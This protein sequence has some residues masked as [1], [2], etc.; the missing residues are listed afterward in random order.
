MGL[1]SINITFQTK[2]ANAIKRSQK[3]IVAM[4]LQDSKEVGG[5]PLFS[6]SDIPKTLS[7]ENQAQIQLAFLGYVS[8][9]RQVLLYVMDGTKTMLKDALNYFAI[10]QF[11]YLVGT[12]EL[13]EADAQTIA[14]WVK[15]E[16][17]NNHMV[18]AV[19]PN[20]QA[21]SEAI[22]NFTTDKIKA[23]T[24]EFTTAQYCA[25]IAGL[26][27]GTP[28]TIS[29]T[30][31]PLPDVSDVTRKPKQEL[32]SAID[33]GEFILFHDGE[34]VKVGRGVTSLT[35]TTADK[36]EAFQ[37]I[38]IVEA[39][40][41]IKSDIRM[42]VQDSYIGKYA[43][44]YDNKCLLIMAI[45]GYLETLEKEGILAKSKST[46]EIDLAAQEQY[47]RNS[48]IDTSDL[49][50]QDIKEANTGKLVFLK[51]AASILDAIED[52]DLAFT[53]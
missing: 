14:S 20:I 7:T 50:E 45:K 23:G 53:I 17:Q 9:P 4:I 38:K 39:A 29:C 35:T 12:P 33:G 27:A 30:Y 49:S 3:G 37:S 40:D 51:A 43:N 36:G 5:H 25:R 8:P 46:V 28:M 24:G 21:D 42:T 26:I 22:I 13:T 47:L 10:Q 15:T 6:I 32:D 18:K 16:R 1:P 41:R 48:G 31:A 19:L 44:S 11:D 2:A 52:I 34:K